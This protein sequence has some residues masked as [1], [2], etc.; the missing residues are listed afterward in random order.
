MLIKT[1]HDACS[2]SH[3][4]VAWAQVAGMVSSIGLITLGKADVFDFLLSC[5]DGFWY[6]TFCFIFIFVPILIITQPCSKAVRHCIEAALPK[7]VPMFFK[8]LL[9]NKDGYWVLKTSK[10][11]HHSERGKKTK[12]CFDVPEWEQALSLSLRFGYFG[13]V[14]ILFIYKC[15]SYDT[16]LEE[17]FYVISTQAGNDIA[18]DV[19]H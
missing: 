9:A 14:C 6:A 8:S 5:F 16:D 4:P 19:Y 3:P 7:Q 11:S 10:N 12:R 13:T 18:Y 1:M 17:W 15:L 2:L